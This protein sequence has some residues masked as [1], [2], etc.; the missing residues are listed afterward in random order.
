LTESVDMFSIELFK[1]LYLMRSIST[2]SSW[3]W[4]F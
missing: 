2:L 4:S 3:I 1:S